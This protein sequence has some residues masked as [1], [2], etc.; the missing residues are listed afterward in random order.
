MA[1]IS[2]LE[3]TEAKLTSTPIVS[4]QIIITTDTK[5]IYRDL[6][7]VRIPIGKDLLIVD[8]L[9]ISPISDK[10]YLLKPNQLYY[11]NS[12]AHEWI[13]LNNAEN[14]IDN[15]I[16]RINQLEKMLY[17]KEVC[18]PIATSNGNI[19]VASN[20]NIIHKYLHSLS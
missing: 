11:Y 17:T 8:E 13:L 4:G 20:G 6:S 15:L 2:L 14:L 19:I 12:S 9:P 1:K 7:S 16:T 10:L 3:T 18:I 5:N